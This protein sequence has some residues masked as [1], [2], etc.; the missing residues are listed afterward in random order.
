MCSKCFSCMLSPVHSQCG[1]FTES[2][3][4]AD[5]NFEAGTARL[6]GRCFLQVDSICSQP[7]SLWALQKRQVQP[8]AAARALQTEGKPGSPP[9]PSRE[10]RWF[11]RWIKDHSS[12]CQSCS[13]SAVCFPLCLGCSLLRCYQGF[14][15]AV[16]RAPQVVQTV[17]LGAAA[18]QHTGISLH[19]RH[20]RKA[21]P[22]RPL[23]VLE[24][25]A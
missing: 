25:A 13:F 14:P 11:Q 19:I 3:G 20:P 4:E 24:D 23:A 1:N 16:S 15:S 18:P 2:L 22:I 10:R 6:D 17:L 12:C 7:G 8:S 9:K 5:C 21:L